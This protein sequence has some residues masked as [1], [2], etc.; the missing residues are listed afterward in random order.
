[1]VP[2]RLPEPRRVG[3]PLCCCSIVASHSQTETGGTPRVVVGCIR[4]QWAT[5]SPSDSCS[6]S[7]ERFRGVRNGI[8]TVR[9]GPLPGRASSLICAATRQGLAVPVGRFCTRRGC[10]VKRSGKRSGSPCRRRRSTG[11]VTIAAAANRMQ[12]LV[13]HDRD[14]GNG[15]QYPH[16]GIRLVFPPSARHLEIVG[17]WELLLTF[18]DGRSAAFEC[19]KRN[20]DW[21]ATCRAIAGGAAELTRNLCQ[22]RG[23][24]IPISPTRTQKA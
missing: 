11:R 17:T 13:E 18:P 4:R 12:R 22:G 6:R 24:W 15:A 9:P 20:G 10:P 7:V 8:P 2:S 21:R 5:D 23:H 1:M 14:R 19:S 3:L 16:T